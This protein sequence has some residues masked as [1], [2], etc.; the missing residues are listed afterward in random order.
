M[1]LCKHVLSIIWPLISQIKH[2]KVQLHIKSVRVS[3]DVPL[4]DFL[5]RRKVINVEQHIHYT[6]YGITSR[7]HLCQTLKARPDQI[8]FTKINNLDDLLL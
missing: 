3:V 1:N 5:T 6:A 8:M 2:G 7:V 4:Q